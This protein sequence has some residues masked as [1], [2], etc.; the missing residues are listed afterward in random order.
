MESAPNLLTQWYNGLHRSVSVFWK[1]FV[2]W[3]IA[4]FTKAEFEK[5]T[6][7]YTFQSSFAI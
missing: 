5:F 6:L 7:K 3:E 4:V 1:A 2:I